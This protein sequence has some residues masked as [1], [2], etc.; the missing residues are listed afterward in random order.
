MMRAV[1]VLQK[2][3]TEE[4]I[5]TLADDREAWS[6]A[7]S[8]NVRMGHS[9]V[10]DVCLSRTIVPLLFLAIEEETVVVQA[11]AKT[12]KAKHFTAKLAAR[13]TA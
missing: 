2:T 6:R 12:T 3:M 13:M 5:V 4:E 7:V 10:I 11:P 1:R 9:N 8:P